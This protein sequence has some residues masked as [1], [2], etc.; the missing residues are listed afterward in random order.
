MNYGRSSTELDI[1][2]SAEV[3]NGKF[4][5]ASNFLFYSRMLKCLPNRE[6]ECRDAGRNVIKTNWGVASLGVHFESEVRSGEERTQRA[7]NTVFVLVIR[8]RW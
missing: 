5:S 2:S 7:I 8:L 4:G 6:D 3:C 1:L